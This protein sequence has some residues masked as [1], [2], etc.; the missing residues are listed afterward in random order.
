MN[1]DLDD[2]LIPNG[3]YR[4]AINLNITKSEASDVGA[5]SSVQPN[6]QLEATT[7]YSALG[8]PSGL[9]VIGI[10]VNS[11]TGFLYWFITNNND[12]GAAGRTR[13]AS[14]GK[15][16]AIV[17]L[18]SIDGAV[19]DILVRGDFL[20]FSTNYPVKAINMIDD[21]LFWTDDYNQPRKI[22]VLRAKSGATSRLVPTFYTK[23][24]QISVAKY[25]PFIAPR[26]IKK[27]KTY[28]TTGATISIASSQVISLLYTIDNTFAVD[29]DTTLTFTT[30]GVNY[31]AP[32][33][34]VADTGSIYNVT[35]G[36]VQKYVGGVWTNITS[37]VSIGGDING[38]LLTF[39]SD[40]SSM[41]ESTTIGV[42]KELIKDKFVKFG[43]RYKFID[44][45]Y[46]LISPFTQ[47]C[48]IPE[49]YKPGSAGLSYLTTGGI[50][51]DEEKLALKHT[52]LE[53]MRNYINELKL[54]IDLPYT[55]RT[56]HSSLHVKEIEVVMS[57]ANDP[58]LKVVESIDLENSNEKSNI[59]TYNYKSTLPYKVLPEDETTRVF[60]N[61]PLRAKTQEIVGNRV[62]YGNIVLGHELAKADFS[63][64]TTER[65]S[66]DFDL[67][68]EYPVQTLKQRRRYQV[69]LVLADKY[70]RQ[71]SVI[72][73]TSSG[74]DTCFLDHQKTLG[75]NDGGSLV[76][77][78]N[79]LTSSITTN[80]NNATNNTYVAA[81]YTTNGN[82][83]DAVI[84]VEVAANKVEEVTV[85]TAGTGYNVGDTITV[86]TSVIGGSTNLV[87][88]L[89]DNDIAGGY[90]DGYGYCLNLELLSQVQG[91]VYVPSGAANSVTSITNGGSHLGVSTNLPTTGGTGTGLTLN[92]T[93][94][95]G[96][97]ATAVTVNN[98]G[99]GYTDG[100]SITYVH[101][102]DNLVV[103]IDIVSNPNPLGW[104]SYKWVVKQK[105]Q[106]F[107]NV[108]APSLIREYP[109]ARERT[110]LTLHGDNINKVPR[111][112][113]PSANP[114]IKIS[115]SE[116]YLFPKVIN[117]FD[118][119]GGD[120][121]YLYS[122]TGNIDLF[123][124]DPLKVISIGAQKDHDLGNEGEILPDT[125]STRYYNVYIPEANFFEA[126]K[127]HLIAELK[128]SYGVPENK[129]LQS[130]ASGT[131]EQKLDEDNQLVIFETEPF[132]TALDL[133]YETSTSGLISELNN[134]YAQ[135]VTIADILMQNNSFNENLVADAFSDIKFEAKNAAGTTLTNVTFTVDYITDAIGTDL[136]VS[137]G[138]GQLGIAE[139]STDVWK[140]RVLEPFYYND[141]YNNPIKVKVTATPNS[142]TALTS[143][144]KTIYLENTDIDLTTITQ[145]HPNTSINAHFTVPSGSTTY[146]ASPY[147]VTGPL[148]SHTDIVRFWA[149]N[150]SKKL[151]FN[152][153]LINVEYEII[154][155]T[156]SNGTVH[157][158]EEDS[159][160]WRSFEIIDN[161]KLRVALNATITGGT[162][163]FLLRAT[164]TA[165]SLNN[166]TDTDETTFVL[167]VD[168]GDIRKF[169]FVA[170]HASNGHD[171]TSNNNQGAC[172]IANN[173][174]I[175]YICTG[176]PNIADFTG[177]ENDFYHHP[178]A[179]LASGSLCYGGLSTNSIN[180]ESWMPYPG[181]S[182]T[183]ELEGH[184]VGI[185]FNVGWSG[186]GGATGLYDN[187]YK[188]I[189]SSAGDDAWGGVGGAFR[190]GMVFVSPPNDFAPETGTV[191]QHH[192]YFKT[193]IDNANE[194]NIHLPGNSGVGNRVYAL[195]PGEGLT[196]NFKIKLLNCYEEMEFDKDCD[197]PHQVD[198]GV[199]FHPFTF[200]VT[201]DDLT[202]SALKDGSKRLSLKMIER[203][204][205]ADGTLT[206]DERSLYI[207]GNGSD[208]VQT[209][210]TPITLLSAYPSSI[211]DS[212]TQEA[213]LAAYRAASM[214]NE[215]RSD[216]CLRIF[217]ATPNPTPL[218]VDQQNY[219]IAGHPQHNLEE[220]GDNGKAH[221]VQVLKWNVGATEPEN[222][223]DEPS[224]PAPGTPAGIDIALSGDTGIIEKAAH[225]QNTDSTTGGV[226]SPASYAPYSLLV[227]N[228]FAQLRNRTDLDIGHSYTPTE[229]SGGTN[230]AH[231]DV[232]LL[233]LNKIY[234]IIVELVDG[235]T[236]WSP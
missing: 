175:G 108:Y 51:E 26:L 22:N 180:I 80:T 222:N 162:Y 125:N 17:E 77:G 131:D 219:Q 96:T 189:A 62:V 166:D 67:D 36:Q 42:E 109:V 46:S 30:G 161:N 103:V 7:I 40:A 211:R 149:D 34:S 232:S 23:E 106:D 93:A 85:T 75:D 150:G 15:I 184:S 151:N 9:R 91:N 171:P 177:V 140:L 123:T 98:P 18:S 49:F 115:P 33:N 155:I 182:E 53:K 64:S 58:T 89:T 38:V 20:N 193:R 105:Q 78:A 191:F 165:A 217:E 170:R 236:D 136:T 176:F 61:V 203:N 79:S 2:R 167:V 88:T 110:W 82:G 114:D 160:L 143:E 208:D 10:Y 198:K 231:H 87:I 60:D 202:V 197:Y 92:I 104:Y 99:E 226:N 230:W 190:Q 212:G 223:W 221:V 19:S 8:N 164:D 174:S 218:P 13:S 5:L 65:N 137:G 76:V 83:T 4:E 112:L 201:A 29:A 168:G 116:A 63:V 178:T 74:G 100:D 102:W 200:W 204:R 121:N 216:S 71:S 224:S 6:I 90:D 95:D 196:S 133:Y 119:S 132:I 124:H 145:T 57:V 66:T 35:I 41:I 31:K 228:A 173:R 156:E 207:F 234:E 187:T 44:N 55:E 210:G 185:N 11:E 127:N 70:G 126:D 122:N 118:D 21:M 69:G 134:E 186:A 81:A 28:L 235:L 45:E 181:G 24:E 50:T 97:E 144:E 72:Q 25:Y 52:D 214:S 43:Y 101:G 188:T 213:A 194:P 179:T 117:T 146:R 147:T 148:E 195:K 225:Y 113:E 94:V 47:T 163:S 39:T 54:Y 154:S 158:S 129:Q 215:N 157:T 229:A 152:T 220:S 14:S 16:N 206:G 169:R 27:L 192:E 59:T 48:F 68:L 3:E 107:Y 138:P 130:S 37:T 183:A 128:N 32:V 120:G 111:S 159:D 233:K 141:G 56:M 139:E 135:G 12:S 86:A 199:S 205:S 142:G 153:G 209:N 172:D 84:T 73:P 1:K 227:P